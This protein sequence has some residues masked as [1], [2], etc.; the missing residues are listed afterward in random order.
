M[1]CSNP[2]AGSLVN[3]GPA[4]RREKSAWT[5]SRFQSLKISGPALCFWVA[6]PFLACAFGAF[7]IE[8]L[9]GISASLREQAVRGIAAELERVA[10][11]ISTLSGIATDIGFALP[12][13]AFGSTVLVHSFHR[14]A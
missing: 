5:L 12:V 4:S 14:R 6:R 13:A 10:M 7:R 3:R 2:T 9:A 8:A 1:F 11:H